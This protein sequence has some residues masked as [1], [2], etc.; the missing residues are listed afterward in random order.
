MLICKHLW[1]TLEN[2]V[3]CC[4]IL[5]LTRCST[6]YIRVTSNALYLF[7]LKFS[8]FLVC[9]NVCVSLCVLFS[10]SLSLSC[11]LVLC[12][13]LLSVVGVWIL[14]VCWLF[15]FSTNTNFPE[16]YKRCVHIDSM[17]ISMHFNVVFIF[18]CL[19]Q[20]RHEKQL[21][22]LIS[23][24]SICNVQFIIIFFLFSQIK[25]KNSCF[26]HLINA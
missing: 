14:F 25:V 13:K 6:I 3:K 8:A 12:M 18:L 15:R 19:F 23:F 22:S 17:L 21:E 2:L 20:I 24:C 1:F 5:V 10:R 16:Q 7:L 4:Y 9:T 26:R 11:S